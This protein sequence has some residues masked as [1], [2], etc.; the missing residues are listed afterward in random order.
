M[1]ISE[2]SLFFPLENQITAV[3]SCHISIRGVRCSPMGKTVPKYALI[4]PG[5]ACQ[6]QVKMQENKGRFRKWK[7]SNCIDCLVLCG[8]VQC[9]TLVT[10]L[11]EMPMKII[12]CNDYNLQYLVQ[13]TFL[14]SF[15][16]VTATDTHLFLL[17]RCWKPQVKWK[18]EAGRSAPLGQTCCAGG[19]RNS[20]GRMGAC[21][22]SWGVRVT[23]W[24]CEGGETVPVSWL[25]SPG[26]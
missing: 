17:Q 8:Y 10:A 5:L 7:W 1:S 9:V 13:P 6:H 22:W 18:S 25:F 3:C 26:Q 21:V 15:S 4:S 14:L 16:Y 19:S 12:Y 23:F 2:G 20:G 24:G 11:Q